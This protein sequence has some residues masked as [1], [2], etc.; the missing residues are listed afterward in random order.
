MEVRHINFGV[1]GEMG[2]LHGHKNSLLEEVFIDESAVPFWHQHSVKTR[3]KNL[4]NAL[5]NTCIGTN[6]D[7]SHDRSIAHN[8]NKEKHTSTQLKSDFARTN[9]THNTLSNN[10]KRSNS[11]FE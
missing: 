2:I 6:D 3:T 4:L 10:V 7:P 11:L 8:F 1:L 5:H 9:S